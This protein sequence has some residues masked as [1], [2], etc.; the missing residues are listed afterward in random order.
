MYLNIL[1]DKQKE[2][3]PLISAF[4]REYTLVGGTAIALYIGHR[5]SVD[6]DLIKSKSISKTNIIKKIKTNKFSWRLLYNDGESIDI[7]VNDVKMTFFQFPFEIGGKQIK[8]IGMKIP[9]LLTIAAMKFYAM[10]RRAKW[11]D[12]VDIYILIKNHFSIEEVSNKANQIFG[13][14]YSEKLF[15]QQI[16]YFEDIDY[17]EPVEWISQPIGEEKIKSELQELALNID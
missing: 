3:L 16:A 14:A 2:I 11:K 5:H 4:K 17:S 1:S 13:Q 9:D 7:L 6:F 15:R 12:Y 8:E 10:G